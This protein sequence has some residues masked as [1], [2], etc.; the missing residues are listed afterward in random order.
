M[1]WEN[2]LHR[3]ARHCQFNILPN[4]T[5]A[6]HLLCAA[7]GAN[8]S[9]SADVYENDL[10]LEGR[11]VV[12][13][14]DEGASGGVQHLLLAAPAAPAHAETRWFRRR[15]NSVEIPTRTYSLEGE[16]S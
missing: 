13:E 14:L 16:T 9:P 8:M 5:A 6:A 2:A 1:A 4:G 12:A 3:H 15:P 11:G 10:A 7:L